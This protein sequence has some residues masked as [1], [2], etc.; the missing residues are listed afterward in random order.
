M[1]AFEY[2]SPPTLAETIEELA[3]RNGAARVL[4]GGTDLI[5]QM[6]LGRLTPQAV[7]DVKKVPEL[8][9]L[10]DEA[11]GLRVG[12][13]VPLCLISDHPSVREQ[14]SCLWD[15][16]LLIGGIQVQSRATIG[17]NLCNSG[18]AADS[19][20]SLIALGGVCVIAGSQ[21]TR[22]VAVESF[23]T[24]PGENVLNPDEVLVELRFNA[25]SANS[26]SHYRRV[27]PRNEMDIAVVGVGASVQLD[28]N[29]ETFVSARIAVGAVAATAL[30]AQQASESLAG[31]PV[32]ADSLSEAAAAVQQIISPISDMR[33]TADYRRHATGVLVRR[34]LETAI[35]RARGEAPGR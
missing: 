22:E 17:G 14:F 28:G 23:C 29:K 10:S 13:A 15:S 8:N 11:G 24:G 1:H 7:V 26:G 33:G 27:I 5:D 25:R 20:P 3:N 31:K 9:I 4:A 12:A 2:V 19:T 32:N 34:V 16:C 21:G 18:P 30:Y 6:R 35:A